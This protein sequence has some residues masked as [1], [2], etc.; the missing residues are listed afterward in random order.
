MT[1][2]K[3]RIS[4]L[5]TIGTFL[6]MGTCS[7]TLCNVLNRAYQYP[8]EN[9]EHATMP[10]AGG[11]VQHGY[12]CGQIWGAVLAAGA[13]AYRQL[14]PGPKAE[15]AALIAS[16]RL[17][18]SF[19]TH[20]RDINCLELTEI[21][22]TSTTLQMVMYFLF[23]GGTIR[24]FS[25]A[26]KFAQIAYDEI[27]TVLSNRNIK[28]LASPV[29]CASLLAQKMGASDLHITMAAGLAGGIGLCG[30][31]CGA[32]GTAIW[33]DGLR[34]KTIKMDFKDPRIMELIEKFLTMTDYE[35]ECSDIVGRSF[36]NIEDHTGY[37]HQGGCKDLIQAL[38]TE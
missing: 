35:F 34:E 5:K 31:A 8:M 38:A 20:F 28:A 21:D 14:G 1:K 7:E 6:K 37:L 10:F 25:M 9:E 29:S 26:A 32:L 36:E 22:K 27:N 23:K 24:C 12:Q 3:S 13:R 19:R 18:E 15:T 17:V 33:I 4:S 30:G 2:N 11:I 16:Q